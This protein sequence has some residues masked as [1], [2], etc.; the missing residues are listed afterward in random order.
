LEEKH[1]QA[2]ERQRKNEERQR[3]ARQRRGR[4]LEIERQGKGALDRLFEQRQ[5]EIIRRGQE[6]AEQLRR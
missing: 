2:R 1:R 5:E 6:R 4:E 3:E